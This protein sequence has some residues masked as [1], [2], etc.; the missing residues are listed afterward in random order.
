MPGAALTYPVLGPGRC[1]SWALP[2]HMASAAF[3]SR[4]H[5]APRYPA[6]QAV[7]APPGAR[8]GSGE[9]RRAGSI[10]PRA[11][12]ACSATGAARSAPRS[13]GRCCLKSAKRRGWRR[14]KYEIKKAKAKALGSGSRAAG[15][16]RRR[17]LT[18]PSWAPARSHGGERPARPYKP[19]Q[20]PPP[21]AAIPRCSQLLACFP[22]AAAR[23]LASCGRAG[24]ALD[25][26]RARPGRGAAGEA[27][28]SGSAAG[29]RGGDGVGVSSA[30][31]PGCLRLPLG[32]SRRGG[33]KER[34][35]PAVPC[36]GSRSAAAWAAVG[37]CQLGLRPGR[38]AAGS[39][40][41][42]TWP[43]SMVT[44]AGSVLAV[45]SPSV[46]GRLVLPLGCPMCRRRSGT[47]LGKELAVVTRR[48]GRRAI[49][50]GQLQ[51]A[52]VK[53]LHI[54]KCRKHASCH[55]QKRCF[56]SCPWQC[57]G[58]STVSTGGC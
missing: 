5:P 7:P 33:T 41:A 57:A 27:G 58:Y 15:G 13:A 37:L 51:L 32:P 44:A 18:R 40:R 2:A 11:T 53:Q 56:P 26:G 23:P 17:H 9:P 29:E 3:G 49:R 54:R 19:S 24:P 16:P 52:Q 8:A 34:S 50:P 4:L 14:K 38:T 30:P 55:C 39:G 42:D 21:Q 10:A 22:P 31:A 35:R 28:G 20:A 45:L 25:P 48:K 36:P 46:H 6:G 1:H 47:R 12:A 43:W